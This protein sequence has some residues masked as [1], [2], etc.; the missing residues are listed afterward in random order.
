MKTKDSFFK[1]KFISR[2]AEKWQKFYQFVGNKTFFGQL[3]SERENLKL[4]KEK[5]AESERE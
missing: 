2:Q 1:W 3:L 5:N 4:K